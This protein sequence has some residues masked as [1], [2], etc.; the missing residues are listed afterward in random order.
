MLS[1]KGNIYST[2]PF[3]GSGISAEERGLKGFKSQRQRI[4]T[5]IHL[6]TEGNRKSM[7][8]TCAVPRQS[9]FQLGHTILPSPRRNGIVS[10]QEKERQF[11]LRVYAPISW[12]T[13]IEDSTL[14]NI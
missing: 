1:H 5:R 10:F 13:P 9:K 8:K 2:C 6:D 4:N 11:S 14:K 3:L 7:H 12:P